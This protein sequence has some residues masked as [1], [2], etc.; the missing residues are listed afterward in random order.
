MISEKALRAGVVAVDGVEY[1]H[2][3]YILEDFKKVWNS[4]AK[5][6]DFKNFEKDLRSIYS[7]AYIAFKAIV[8]ELSKHCSPLLRTDYLFSRQPL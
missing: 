6:V 7:T 3:R 1:Y 5:R 8:N 2:E 4:E